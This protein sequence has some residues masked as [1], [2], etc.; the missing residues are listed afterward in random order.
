MCDEIF[1]FFDEL[2]EKETLGAEDLARL[3]ELTEHEDEMVRVNACDSLAFFPNA[4]AFEALQKRLAKDESDLVRD[5]ALLSLTDIMGEVGADENAMRELFLSCLAS[6]ESAGCKLACLKGLYLLGDTARLSEI[7]SYLQA[8]NYQ[9]R[10]AAVNLLGELAN[11]SNSAEI[12]QKLQELQETEETNA[13]Q[14]TIK[15]VLDEM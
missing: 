13:V 10:C 1:D 6:E 12:K 3:L 8:E 4:Q 15:R 9:K 14:S 2:T 5:Y 11:N 7:F